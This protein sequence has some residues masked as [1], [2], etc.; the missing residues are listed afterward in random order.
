MT[1]I[2]RRATPDHRSSCPLEPLDCPFKDADCT[3]KIARKDMEDH[4]T[5]NQQKHILL[6]F[7]GHQELKQLI[8]RETDI[9]GERI[10]D[11]TTVQLLR[12]M[13]ST[14]E[15]SLDEFGDTLTFRVT[16]F[17]QLRREKKPWH[18]PPF[19]I[20][21]KVKVH[22]A[23]YPSGVGRGQGTHVSLSLILIAVVR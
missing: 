5:A 1:G 11:H 7:Q 19:S 15:R 16:D 6:T 2:R 14:L 3:E 10:Q 23:V 4:M 20:G 18:S 22:L 9:L 8:C 12:C 21:D 13:K 17:S